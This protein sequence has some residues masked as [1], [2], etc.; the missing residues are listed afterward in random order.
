MKTDLYNNQGELTGSV[1]LS[2]DLFG[3]SENNAVV[4]QLLRVFGSHIHQSTSSTKTRAEVSGGGK[5]PWKQKGTGRARHGSRRSPIWV[6]GGVTHG[7][8]PSSMLSIP[9]SM[10]RRALTSL[11]STRRTQKQIAIIDDLSYSTPKTQNILKLLNKLPINKNC[12]I[13]LPNPIENTFLSARN[14]PGLEVTFVGQ[15]SAIDVLSHPGLIID[16][17]ALPL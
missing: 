17:R 7:P 14:I 16:S 12:L 5:K 2:E 8:K 3:Q 10:K 6:H 4:T 13:L 11:L 1:P 9:K 15:L